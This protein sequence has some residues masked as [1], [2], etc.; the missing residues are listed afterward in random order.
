MQKT[1]IQKAGDDQ[2]PTEKT[3]NNIKTKMTIK[4]FILLIIL[5]AF[6]ISIFTRNIVE[7][8]IVYDHLNNSYIHNTSSNNSSLIL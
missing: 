3:S 8:R 6:V 7:P 4:I 5:I 2:Q 1:D